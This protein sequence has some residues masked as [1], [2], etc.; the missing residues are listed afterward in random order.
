MATDSLVET[1]RGEAA[2]RALEAQLR[3]ALPHRYHAVDLRSRSDRELTAYAEDLE[4]WRNA[5]GCR[6]GE[7]GMLVFLAGAVFDI[8]ASLTSGS[9]RGWLAGGLETIVAVVAGGGVGKA[10]GIGWARVRSA[11]LAREIAENGASR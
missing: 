8:A 1:A 3:A 9:G 11:A 6:A 7:A 10:V 5:C 4:T 2:R